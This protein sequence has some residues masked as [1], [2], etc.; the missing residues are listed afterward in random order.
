MT[1]RSWNWWAQVGNAGSPS[2]GM[3]N[4]AR[5]RRSCL[6]TSRSASSA[7]GRSNLLIATRSAKSSM[8][9]FSSCIEAPYS[10]VMTYT[11]WSARSA[12]SLSRLP[13]A[14]RLHQHEAEAG[15]D[16][17]VD[18]RPGGRR[19]RVVRLPRREGAHV[20]A[21]RAERVHPDPVAEQR[22]AGAPLR[23]VHGEDRD[24]EVG[25]VGEEAAHQLV[26]Q[27]RLSGAAGA[28][29][30]DHRAPWPVVGAGAG[31]RRARSRMSRGSPPR[32]G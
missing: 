32:Q 23:R 11:D 18:R 10:G 25:E 15:G 26:G 20:D 17:D 9:I 5:L 6:R 12:I 27:R 21:L 29:N 31:Q 19:Q 2:S 30:A 28:R 22:A 8:S 7:P 4:S 14:R 24:R 1:P 3:V 13:G 16:A